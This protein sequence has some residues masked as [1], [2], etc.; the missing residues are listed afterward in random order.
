MHQHGVRIS[1]K[2]LRYAAEFFCNLFPGRGALNH[3]KQF[4]QAVE[5]LQTELGHLTDQAT[6]AELLERF[7]IGA[8]LLDGA[9]VSDKGRS[10]DAAAQAFETLMGLKPFWARRYR[11]A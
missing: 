2:K 6:G 8:S 11:L 7:A 1:A 3:Q 4:L 5:S 10:T 9:L